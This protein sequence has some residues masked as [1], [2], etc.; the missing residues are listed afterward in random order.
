MHVRIAWEIHQNQQRQS[1]ESQSDPKK[2]LNMNLNLTPKLNLGISGGPPQGP[3][4]SHPPQTHPKPSSG[5]DT[6][7]S[8]LNSHNSPFGFAHHNVAGFLPRIPPVPTPPPSHHS[9]QPPGVVRHSPA[10]DQWNRLDDLSHRIR[11][12]SLC[13]SSFCLFGFFFSCLL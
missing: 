10:P 12:G 7:P 11:F 6:L 4:P 3:S 9:M 13:S 1:R 2:M 8:P 5:F